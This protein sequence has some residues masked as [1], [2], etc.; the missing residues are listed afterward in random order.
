MPDMIV[1]CCYEILR[2]EKDCDFGARGLLM[3]EYTLQQIW[4]EVDNTKTTKDA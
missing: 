4:T 2:P 3:H 1:I